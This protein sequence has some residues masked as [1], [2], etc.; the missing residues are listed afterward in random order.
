MD[1]EAQLEAVELVIDAMPAQ[2]LFEQ[3]QA[4]LKRLQLE[5]N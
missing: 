1:E 4:E 2:T 3:L 5:M